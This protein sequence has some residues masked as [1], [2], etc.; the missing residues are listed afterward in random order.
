MN[1]FLLDVLF[2]YSEAGL[3]LLCVSFL[4]DSCDDEA[5]WALGQLISVTRPVETVGYNITS[6]DLPASSS[7]KTQSY[8]ASPSWT[9]QP[10]SPPLT[11][12]WSCSLLPLKERMFVM[13]ISL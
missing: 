7:V 2:V 13:T 4:L 12:L 3:C 11:H 9:L 1:F 8:R 6:E 5:A 10:Y